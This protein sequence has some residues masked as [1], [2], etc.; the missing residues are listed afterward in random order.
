MVR[1][2]FG[3]KSVDEIEKKTKKIESD[4]NGMNVISVKYPAL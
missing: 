4:E 1:I 2:G 3:I